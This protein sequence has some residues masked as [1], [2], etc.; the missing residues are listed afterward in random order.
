MNYEFQVKKQDLKQHRI[1]KSELL[2]LAEGQ[3][4]L[5]VDRFAFTANNLTYGASGDSLGYWR[6]FPA[7]GND[8]NSWGILPVWAFADVIESN[9]AELPVGERLYG[10]FPPATYLTLYPKH[11]TP[12]DV[13]D[14]T[15]HR[16]VLP[17]LY[18]R[19]SRVATDGNH[20][21]MADAAR[22]LLAPLH[23]TSFCLLDMLKTGSWYD[24][25]QI[26]IVSASS[27]TSMG[28][29]YGLQTVESSP[30]VVG[31]TSDENVPFVTGLGLYDDVIDYQSVATEVKLR[32]TVVV[33]MAGNA[34]LVATLEEKLSDHLNH[35]ISVGLTH[36]TDMG[37]EHAFSAKVSQSNREVFFAPNYILDR[38]KDWGAVEFEQRS[39]EFVRAA[40]QATFGWMAADNRSGL[41]DLSAVYPDVCEGSLSPSKGL[42]IVM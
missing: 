4:R 31:L 36:W 33:D 11:V 39:S 27:K 21:E 2:D 16:Q 13:M 30:R 23:L 37:D 1:V 42:V 19:Y 5:K 41:A 32:K 17:A 40:A 22:I 35:Y 20:D 26:I 6:F 18:N 9:C 29:A 12:L 38:L 8:D 34:S 15:P 14:A 28:L 25:E 7:A 24:A 3:I 10:Y